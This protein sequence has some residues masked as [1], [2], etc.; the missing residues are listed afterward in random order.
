MRFGV[1]L[2]ALLALLWYGGGLL[3]WFHI[4]YKRGRGPKDAGE[5]VAFLL[6]WIAIIVGILFLLSRALG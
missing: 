5:W 3:G 1:L 6:G 4:D 2:L